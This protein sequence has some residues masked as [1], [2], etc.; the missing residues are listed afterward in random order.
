MT[1]E[2]AQQ[3]LDDSLQDGSVPQSALKAVAAGAARSGKT[4][5]KKHIF[6]IEID[7]DFSASTGVCEAPVHSIRSFCCQMFDASLPVWV[8]LTQESLIGVLGRKLRQGY[9]HGRLAEQAARILE[10]SHRVDSSSAGE[11]ASSGKPDLSR[12]V[13]SQTSNS[14]ELMVKEAKI[15]RHR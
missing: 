6:G 1:P 3:I 2:K 12:D 15:T 11:A 9:I 10:E 8:H 4:L 7:C 5:S 13:S 14:Q